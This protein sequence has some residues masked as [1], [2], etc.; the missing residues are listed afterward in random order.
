[1]KICFITNNLDVKN[2]WGRSLFNLIDG[3]RRADYK[4]NALVENSSGFDFENAVI[5]G[6]IIASAVRARSFLKKCDIINAHDI[7][8]FGVIAM[9]ANF[10]LKKK[11]IITAHGTYSVIPFYQKGAAGFFKKILSKMVL[12]KADKIVS[13]SKYTA[14]QLNKIMPDLKTEVVNWGI[15]I[16]RFAKPD[17]SNGN[18]E[19]I[20]KLKPFI[21]SVGAIKER[22]GF[23]ISIKAFAKIKDKYPDLK[24][25]IAG[26]FNDSD[27]YKK[28]LDK[29]IADF[30]IAGRVLF[31]KN[32]SDEDITGFYKNSDFFILTPINEKHNFEGFGLVY[33]EAGACGKAVIG[34]RNCGAEDAVQN[35][36]TGILVSQNDV[37]GISNAMEKLLNDKELS[38]AMGE[39]GFLAA[40]EMPWSGV[41]EKYS[42][43]FENI[44]DN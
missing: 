10:G 39:K 41:I 16:N 2:G 44:Y 6:S 5:S 13:V 31:F 42:K 34:S 20:E 3:A 14:E 9:L 26:H 4:V 35:N 37:A 36:I 32:V 24:Y 29:I 30:G 12:K 8:P 43:I 11:I 18:Y 7:W 25:V 23:H 38:R 1:M 22:K 33:L 17:L 19:Y 28:K 15:D 27:D 40:K 21:L